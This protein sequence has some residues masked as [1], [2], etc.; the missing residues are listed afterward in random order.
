MCF[1]Q[2]LDGRQPWVSQDETV[3]DA[4]LQ[5]LLTDSSATVRTRAVS[6]LGPV[7]SDSSVRQALRTV[8]TTDESPYLRTVSTHAL[9]GSGLI[10]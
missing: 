3:R 8:S 6:M 4:V 10:Q 9:E 2:A 1:G 5:A 7:Q